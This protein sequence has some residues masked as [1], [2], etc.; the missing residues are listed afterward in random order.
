MRKKGVFVEVV[1]ARCKHKQVVFGKASTFV[2]C[3]NCGKLL[4]RPKGG[5]SKIK[6]FVR[7]VLK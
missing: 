1:C 6:S 7:R 3:E 4:V 5:K 2:K